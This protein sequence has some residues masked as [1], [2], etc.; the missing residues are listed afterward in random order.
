MPFQKS[1]V[2]GVE[3]FPTESNKFFL[4]DKYATKL[5]I[6]FQKMISLDKSSILGT[7]KTFSSG[8]IFYLG[9]FSVFSIFDV[10]NLY[11]TIFLV[12]NL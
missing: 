8:Q 12:F 2:P 11:S 5:R 3:L 4:L 9:N 10:F 7:K 6:L 1:Q